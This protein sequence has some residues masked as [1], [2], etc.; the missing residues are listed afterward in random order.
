MKAGLTPLLRLGL[1][2]NQVVI[3]G[4]LLQEGLLT[5]S[6]LA[7]ITNI[8]R[9]Q[10]YADTEKLVELGLLDITKKQQ[11]KFIAAKATSLLSLAEKQQAE[12]AKTQDLIRQSLPFFESLSSH[13]SP[14]AQIKYF[15][16]LAKIRDAYEQELA[17]CRSTEVLSFV[18][19][20][21]DLYAFF[22]EQF[23]N[24]WNT[25]FVAQKNRSKIL[26]H[27]SNAARETAKHDGTYKRETRLLK[28]FPLKVNI[29]VFGNNV[30]IVSVHDQLATW[31]ESSA[32]ADSYRILFQTCWQQA[33]QAT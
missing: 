32:I 7:R 11:R 29:D 33:K 19:S 16:G 30:L 9:Q 1:T 17:A 26:V 23:W 10:I 24:K 15:E 5:A 18:G 3:Y 27:D 2:K 6:E 12:A 20:V 14:Q 28:D 4:T 31:I 13:S 22:P 8:N 21:E 25:R